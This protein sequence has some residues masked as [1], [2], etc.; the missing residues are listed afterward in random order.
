METQTIK[1]EPVS[2]TQL[3][4]VQ[5]D[6]HHGSG[7]IPPHT[8][9]TPGTNSGAYLMHMYHPLYHGIVYAYPSVHEQSH[10]L[11]GVPNVQPP[12]QKRRQVKLACT[13]CA[14]ACKRCDESRPCPRCIKYNISE[15]CV[16]GQRKE[17][18]KGIKRGPYKRKNKIATPTQASPV[19]S[20]QIGLALHPERSTAV[21][22]VPKTAV[23]P[24]SHAYDATTLPA[25]Q[26]PHSH[27]HY[28]YYYQQR[29]QYPYSSTEVHHLDPGVPTPEHI[30]PLESYSFGA[31]SAPVAHYPV[32]T[33]YDMP[34]YAHSSVYDGTTRQYPP[35]LHK[36]TTTGSSD[37]DTDCSVSVEDELSSF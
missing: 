36:R 11:A 32:T 17:R 12:R 28:Q 7:Y 30:F 16:D 27:T 2:S 33:S 23:P 35:D 29:L 20:D 6:Y 3:Y 15:S 18:K 5:S 19:Q 14:S 22:G 24:Y 4:P 8:Q 13:N 10:M 1:T 34:D 9:A 25:A 26:N 31:Y 21:L 37:T